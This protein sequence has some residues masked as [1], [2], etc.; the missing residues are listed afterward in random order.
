[1][2]DLEPKR[3]LLEEISREDKKLLDYLRLEFK[4]SYNHYLRVIRETGIL[5]KPLL[6][7]KTTTTSKR[8]NVSYP[9]KT[10]MLANTRQC[11]RD[12]A[13]ECVKLYQELRKQ[14]VRTEYP[15]FMFEKID[16]RINWRD[17]YRIAHDG[18]INI[19]VKKGSIV[20][21]KLSGSEKDHLVLE[22]ALG[23]EYK[24]NT[25]EISKQGDDFFININ[26]K[27]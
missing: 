25:A 13:V 4:K 10:D 12:K 21:A 15:E 5:S 1:M 8:H 22:K 17:G 3:F 19:S 6:E 14:N 16:P 2:L 20:C 11:A 18:T 7:K 23:D 27:P 9:I 26:V 24:F